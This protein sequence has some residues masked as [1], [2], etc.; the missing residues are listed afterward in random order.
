MLL[1]SSE[2]NCSLAWEPKDLPCVANFGFLLFCFGSSLNFEPSSKHYYICCVRVYVVVLLTCTAEN[3]TFMV[4]KSTLWCECR[5]WKERPPFAPLCECFGGKTVK[6]AP[7]F[8][9]IPSSTPVG[10]H[11][12][13]G[14]KKDNRT[15]FFI[16]VYSNQFDL[17]LCIRANS[18][19]GYEYNIKWFLVIMLKV[20]C[21]CLELCLMACGAHLYHNK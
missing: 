14:M 1:E 20:C 13:F 21:A 2:L 11:W 19:H 17:L 6:L 15:L 12:S 4:C 5:C 18:K 9:G 7:K 3:A 16:T 10:R 8:Y